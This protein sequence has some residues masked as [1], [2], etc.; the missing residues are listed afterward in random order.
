MNGLQIGLSAA[1]RDPKLIGAAFTPW[2]RQL[3]LLEA[4]EAGPRVHVIAAGRR[5]GKSTIAAAVC[6]WDAL[7]RPQ[8]DGLVRQGER[9]FSVSVAT[10]REQAQLIID[11][12]RTMVEASP[13]LRPMLEPSSE[14]VLKFSNGAA[15]AAFPC[16]SRGG[17]GWPISCLVLD[18]F[19]HFIDTDGNSAAESVWRALRP[20]TAQFG[21]QARVLV[22]ST[23]WGADGA[24]A[25]LWGQAKRGE[26][27][28]AVAHHATSA[29][30]NPTIDEEF[31][32]AE[33]QMD[34][35]GFANEYLAQFVPG[36]GAYLDAQRIAECVAER[37]ELARSEASGWVVGLDLGFASDPTGIC[38]VGRDRV[39]PERLRVG[40]SRAWAPQ[41]SKS[42]EERR[43][44]EDSVLSNVAEIALHF[45]APVVCDQHLAPQVRDFLGRRGV[46]VH[47]LALSAET[48]D[49]AFT[50][51][52]ARI[53][54]A[55][56]ELYPHEDL[57]RELR[58][59][60]TRFSANKSSV[61]LPR[62]SKGH[63]DIAVALALA[64]WRLDRSG[65]GGHTV[66]PVAGYA[67]GGLISE[68]DR[69]T[70][71][72]PRRAPRWDDPHSSDISTMRF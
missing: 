58:G 65:I 29:E 72:P 60:Q 54:S 59:I 32:A 25:D 4:I 40:L 17:R 55:G 11:S 69:I 2:P 62:T 42:F 57:L 6:V 46:H 13:L 52:R 9:R 37:G 33:R 67:G 39:A 12:A 24:F 1:C 26:L 5:G 16:T 63:S 34:P 20:S 35:D 10:K 44:I 66:E 21:D 8:L 48:K 23:P 61:V 18:E 7:L 22:C 45:G 56:L 36:G 15:I 28:A 50:E 41:R 31:L 68:L 49:L 3:E 19:S 30:L 51:L 53:Y 38:V 70:G 14:D 43:A 71:A 64:V 27:G 47:T